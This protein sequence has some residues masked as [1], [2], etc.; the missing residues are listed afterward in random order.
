MYPTMT[1]INEWFI[2]GVQEP[3]LDTYTNQEILHGLD[4]TP[5]EFPNREW[6]TIVNLNTDFNGGETYFPNEN[7][8]VTPETG[9]ASIFQ[10][11]HHDHGVNKVYQGCR[12]TVS[13]WFS[14]D[15]NN[16]L[17]NRMTNDL[18]LTYLNL[19]NY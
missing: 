2:G 3:H 7:Y 14:G 16:M 8:T 6:T 15:I 1:N 11:I 12:Y 19:K 4:Q 17:S 10:G 18:S 5:P 13:I 9:K